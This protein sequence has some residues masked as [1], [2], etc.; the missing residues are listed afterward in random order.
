MSK[1]P[2]L[3]YELQARSQDNSTVIKLG[4]P[5]ATN[6][7]RTL[8]PEGYWSFEGYV[9]TSLEPSSAL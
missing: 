2:T 5:S 1:S 6:L 3:F 9:K 7:K 8:L 4:L